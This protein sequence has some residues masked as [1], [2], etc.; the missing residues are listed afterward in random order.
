MSIAIDLEG[1]VVLVCGVARGGVGGATAREVAKAGATVFGIDYAQ[2]FL[3][4]TAAD[5]EQAGGRFHGMVADLTDP[6]QSDPIIRTVVGR[7]GKL[8]G[9]A[10]VC[11]G[12]NSEDW[13]PLE[14]MRLETF[15][16][17]LNWNLEYVFRICRDAAAY[18][19]GNKSKGS[20]VNV[21]SISLLTSAPYHGPYGA[22]KAGIAALTRTMAHE[23]G[24]YGIR[25]NTVSPG[26]V[27]SEAVLAMRPNYTMVDNEDVIVQ[28]AEELANG[29]VFLLSDLASGISGQNLSIDGTNSTKFCGGPNAPARSPSKSH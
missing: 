3:D 12:M 2:H 22:A 26:A 7:L 19:I 16:K 20:L 29:I 11:G 1:Q 23:W 28:S 10:N 24:P 15:R 17:M 18:M 8:D 4:E 13:Q 14:E 25:A 21:G 5:I 6:A 27:M 9:V